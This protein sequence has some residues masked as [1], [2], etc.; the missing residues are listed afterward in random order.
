[1]RQQSSGPDTIDEQQQQQQDGAGAGAAAQ[2]QQRNEERGAGGN[3]AGHAE[4]LRARFF[5]HFAR[6]RLDEEVSFC[7]WGSVQALFYLI[8]KERGAHGVRDLRMFEASHMWGEH[9]LDMLAVGLVNLFLVIP[10]WQRLQ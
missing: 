3:R 10:T 7:E 6:M 2:Q 1:M 9:K 5:R 8:G 4:D